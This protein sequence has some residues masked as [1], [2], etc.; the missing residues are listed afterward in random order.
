MSTNKAPVND[1]IIVAVA[2]LVDDA[3][4]EH[5]SRVILIS[6]SRS[7]A[8]ASVTAIPKGRARSW[9]RQSA[10]GPR[11]PGAST[12]RRTRLRPS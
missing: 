5:A 1:A 7:I 4:R 8:L 3:S 2:R 10:C 9:V 11:C 6:S 12:M